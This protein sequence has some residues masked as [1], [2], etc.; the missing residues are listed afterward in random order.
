MAGLGSPE[1]RSP[2]SLESRCSVIPGWKSRAFS[3]PFCLIPGSKAIRIPC[4]AALH[5]P[6]F[7]CV[8][9]IVDGWDGRWRGSPRLLWP[10]IFPSPNARFL[11]LYPPGTAPLHRPPAR[12]PL[13]K[14]LDP[15]G[16]MSSPCDL[17]P[18]TQPPYVPIPL[19]FT[20]G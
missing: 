15:T 1:F 9:L 7:P 5:I 2:F 14:T 17:V 11:E 6:G 16:I 3:H 12:A 4:S 20:S 13:W 10:R 19:C 18:I 8:E